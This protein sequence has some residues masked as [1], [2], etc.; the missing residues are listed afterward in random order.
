MKLVTWFA[1]AT[2]AFCQTVSPVEWPKLVYAT[3]VGAGRNSTLTGLAIDSDGHAYVGGS[4]PV[5]GGAGCGYL[6]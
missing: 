4:G 5:A 3:Y 2:F 6:V 1:S